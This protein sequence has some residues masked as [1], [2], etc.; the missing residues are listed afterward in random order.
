MNDH[1]QDEV[2]L[3]NEQN[4]RR[5]ANEFDRPNTSYSQA[6]KQNYNS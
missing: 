5:S 3:Q 1:S 4:Y 6:N 2:K